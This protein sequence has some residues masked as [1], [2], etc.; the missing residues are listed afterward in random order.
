[1]PNPPLKFSGDYRPPPP[2]DKRFGW[3][4]LGGI[5]ILIGVILIQFLYPHWLLK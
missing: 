3:A 4:V 5:Y 2:E 1:M